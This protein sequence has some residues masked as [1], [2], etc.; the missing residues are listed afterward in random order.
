MYD[1][2][3][4]CRCN[5]EWKVMSGTSSAQQQPKGVIA[6]LNFAAVSP[7]DVSMF[8]A[9]VRKCGDRKLYGTPMEVVLALREI[10]N[11]NLYFIWRAGSVVGMAAY[12]RRPDG[13]VYLSNLAIDPAYQ[14]QGIGRAAMSFLLE[15]SKNAKRI[16]LVTHPDNQ[17]AIQFYS[18]LGFEVESRRENHFGDGEPCLV[19]ALA[20]S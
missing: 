18:S 14:R 3:V 7:D 12:R 5:P 1:V 6:T 15:K 16:D 19:L 11:N 13:S 17:P 4:A 8:M 2:L 10:I 9:L 20:R